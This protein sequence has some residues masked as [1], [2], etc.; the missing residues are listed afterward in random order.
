MY[1]VYGT[2]DDHH[3][4]FSFHLR[5]LASVDPRRER[6]EVRFA[7]YSNAS[8]ATN[9]EYP[10][11][12]RKKTSTTAQALLANYK[13]EPQVRG[14]PSESTALAIPLIINS[15]SLVGCSSSPQAIGTQRDTGLAEASVKYLYALIRRHTASPSAVRRLPSESTT[16]ATPPIIYCTSVVSSGW[17]L[18]FLVCHWNTERQRIGC[19][20]VVQHVCAMVRRQNI[21]RFRPHGI[22]RKRMRQNDFL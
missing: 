18:I 8:A 19:G 12:N 9:I 21:C 7:I 5:V 2:S 15:N 3:D 20:Q 16:L 22:V 11:P 17:L 1:P 6:A 13:P 4:I 10:S 14:H